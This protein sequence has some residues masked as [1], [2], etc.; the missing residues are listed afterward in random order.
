MS[1]VF[2]LIALT[3]L[4]LAYIG[5]NTTK[6]T[7]SL[8][9]AY[10]MKHGCFL[11]TYFFTEYNDQDEIKRIQIAEE[12]ERKFRI[13]RIDAGVNLREQSYKD[14]KELKREVDKAYQ[15]GLKRMRN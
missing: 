6:P 13:M 1:A 9:D 10:Y 2:I 14:L 7:E 3:V 4:L 8:L 5:Q 11:G 12:I 15:K